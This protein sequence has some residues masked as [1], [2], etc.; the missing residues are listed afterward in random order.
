MFLRPEEFADDDAVERVDA[1]FD[2]SAEE[3]AVHVLD[4]DD[5][6]VITSALDPGQTQVTISLSAD[7]PTEYF[8]DEEPEPGPRRV[9]AT[10]DEEADHEPGLDEIL[11]SQHYTFDRDGQ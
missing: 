11:T 5:S 8:D 9:D 6:P 4:P 3:A 10:V 7:T 1:A 2:T